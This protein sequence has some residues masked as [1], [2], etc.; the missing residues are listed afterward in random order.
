MSVTLL[1]LYIQC[2]FPFITHGQHNMT[3]NL[4]ILGGGMIIQA[5]PHL[6]YWGGGYI[7]HHPPPPATTPMYKLHRADLHFRFLQRIIT[8]SP[9]APNH[10]VIVDSGRVLSLI[11]FAVEVCPIT[12]CIPPAT[13]IGLCAIQ[14]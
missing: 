1:H 7:P 8:T 4:E 12:T 6:K 3:F 13:A 2:N 11:V 10:A 5:I 14:I 9:R